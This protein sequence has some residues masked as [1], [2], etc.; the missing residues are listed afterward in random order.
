SD[1]GA[2]DHRERRRLPSRRYPRPA[3]PATAV[4]LEVSDDDFAVQ[5][6]CVGEAE[7][8]VVGRVHFLE[9]VDPPAELAAGEQGSDLR[10][11]GVVRHFDQPVPNAAAGMDDVSAGAQRI[12][13]LSNSARGTSS[14][15]QST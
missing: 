10:L 12:D 14:L 7:R 5:G 4:P 13:A 1:R 9:V 6:A 11:A 15:S 2:E 3:A 8:L